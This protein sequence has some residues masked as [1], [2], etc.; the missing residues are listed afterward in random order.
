MPVRRKQE[1]FKD[2]VSFS[3]VYPQLVR[4]LAERSQDWL[5]AL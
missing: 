3:T 2:E 4:A 5:F 1:I